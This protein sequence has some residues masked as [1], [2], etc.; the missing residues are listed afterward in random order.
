MNPIQ[1]ISPDEFGDNSDY[2]KIE[3]SYYDDGFLTDD[4]DEIINDSKK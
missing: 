1:V 3:L 2:D 4:N